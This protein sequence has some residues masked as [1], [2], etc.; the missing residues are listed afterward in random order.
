MG[1][2]NSKELI[3]RKNLQLSVTKGLT[4]TAR[5]LPRKDRL[6]D[7][8]WVPL[9]YTIWG[10]YGQGGK[11]WGWNCSVVLRTTAGMFHFLLR[12]AVKGAT[13]SVDTITSTFFIP[14]LSRYFPIRFDTSGKKEMALIVIFQSFVHVQLPVTTSANCWY[15]EYVIKSCPAL[16]KFIPA[17]LAF[18]W[19]ILLP[20]IAV[21][22][23]VTLCPLLTNSSP[24][25]AAGVTWP[26]TGKVTIKTERGLLPLSSCSLPVEKWHQSKISSKLHVMAS[27]IMTHFLWKWFP[28][29]ALAPTTN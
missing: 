20:S 17:S 29:A 28:W 24:K 6:S 19:A 16:I 12:H 15:S 13:N 2:S 14:D 8:R 4:M 18:F 22:Q 3:V 11:W 25:V 10:G 9:L 21:V 23:R 27:L 5:N 7:V 26:G 1:H